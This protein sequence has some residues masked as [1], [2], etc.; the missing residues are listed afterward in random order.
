MPNRLATIFLA[1]AVLF[2]NAYCACVTAAG[3]AERSDHGQVVAPQHEGCHGHGDGSEP[4]RDNPD[5]SHDCG[6]CTGTVF[7]YA[8]TVKSTLATPFISP[9]VFAAPAAV[10][11]AFSDALRCNT[12]H[13]SGLPPPVPR[14]TLLSLFCCLNN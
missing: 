3:P 4:Q 1:L 9:L 8:T 5:N 6:H 13:Q 2:A 10:E 11:A 7:A 12:G 14:P